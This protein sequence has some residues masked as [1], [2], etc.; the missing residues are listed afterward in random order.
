MSEYRNIIKRRMVV[1]IVCAAC[2]LVFIGSAGVYGYLRSIGS[3][4]H[5]RDFST[6]MY[7][8]L[9]FAMAAVMIVRVVRMWKVLKDEAKLKAMYV[10]EHDERFLMIQ[11][12]TG[13]WA[14][15]FVM[16]VVL[17]AG[18]GLLFAG[19]EVV[20]FTLLMV[21]SF[22]AFTRAGLWFYYNRKY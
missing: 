15:Q 22:I 14:L 10:R 21:A 8:G 1:L 4:E 12:K 17:F 5:M 2:A 7:S 13:G 3:E 9:F 6:G 11:S 20:G 16:G 19:Q 18:M